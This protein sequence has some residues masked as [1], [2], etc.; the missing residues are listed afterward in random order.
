VSG[1]RVGRSLLSVRS[2]A[3]D[4]HPHFPRWSR[5]DAPVVLAFASDWSLDGARAGELDAIRSELRGLGAALVV[6]SNTGMW[7]FRPDD[8]IERFAASDRQVDEEVARLAKVYGIE[9]SREGEVAEAVFVLDSSGEVRF[10]S[11]GSP[12]TG[13]MHATLASALAAAGRALIAPP[14]GPITVSRREWVTAVLVAGFALFAFDGC[15]TPR[16][17]AGAKSAPLDRPIA[18]PPSGDLDVVLRVNGTAHRLRIEPRVSLLDVL[19]ER[20]G[21]TGSKKGC[22]HG[23]CGACTVL[24][25]NRR[26]CACLTLAIMVQGSDIT[27]IEGLATGDALHPLQEAFVAQD[28]LQCGY[29]TPGQI[30]SA[31]GLIAEGHAHTDDEVREQM[32]GNLCRC[33]AYPNIVAAIQLARKGA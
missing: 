32:S 14:P 9:R 1:K 7:S 31:V 10:A 5:G 11:R 20:I 18:P 16:T 13:S 25:D 4:A 23:Q 8:D 28:A 21:L 3:P 27:T 17:P 33:G 19:R 22:D 29:C 30:M 15:N 24:V 12:E 26:V 2:K 6:V